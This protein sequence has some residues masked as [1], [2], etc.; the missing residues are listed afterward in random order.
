[1]EYPG[2]TELPEEEKESVS[3]PSFQKN[4]KII[5]LASNDVNDQSLFL[6]GLTQNIVILYDLF[7]SMGF[8]S[9][10][11]QHPT[12]AKEKKEFLKGYR[13]VSQPDII[14]QGMRVF[15]MI[16]IGMSLDAL[17]RGYLRSIGS[18]IV[19]LY[20]GN[21]LNIDLETIQNTPSIFFYHHI[22]GEIDEI[23]TSPHYAQHLDYASVLNRVDMDRGRVV[24]YV[25]DPCFLTQYG[26]KETLQWVPPK[27]WTVQNIVIMDP[28]ISFQKCCFYPILLVEAFSR[29]YPEWKGVVHVVNGDRLKLSAN[30]REHFL[31]SLSLFQ[32]GR[33]LLKP[34]STIHELLKE[35]RS[36]C[37]IT[38]QVNNDYNYM[39]LELMYC[40]YPILH[41]SQ[42]WR[43]YGYHYAT[44]EWDKAV[45]TLHHAL[46][47]HKDSLSTYRTHAANLAWKHSIHHPTIQSRWRKILS[48]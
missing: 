48:D 42:G 28:N 13:A 33:I 38:H 39:T 40:N 41:N 25:W 17:T 7:E 22:V 3:L 34:R 37:F 10:L 31:S 36:A 11:L 29:T 32:T 24:P 19:K 12:Q 2:L 27:S 1:M 26:S 15:M 14:R 35:H 6:N 8:Q 21:I 45:G 18:R 9:Y 30:A 23:W 16:E 46:A 4:N 20:L 47:L 44:E 5:V 43:E